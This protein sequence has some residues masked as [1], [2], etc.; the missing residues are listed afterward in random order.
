MKNKI[1][2]LAAALLLMAVASCREKSEVLDNYAFKDKLV[3]QKADTSFAAKFDILWSALD[4]NYNLWD[5]EASQGVDWDKVYDTYYPRF[6]ALDGQYT[7]P[8]TVVKALMNEAFG[9][10]HDGH[11]ALQMKNHKTGKF[12]TC[13]PSDLRNADRPDLEI[14][15]NFQPDLSYYET[16]NAGENKV[17]ESDNV[18]TSFNDHLDDVKNAIILKSLDYDEKS[19]DGG[20][21]PVDKDRLDSLKMFK[22]TLD[23]LEEIAPT[24]GTKGTIQA[25]NILMLHYSYLNVKGAEVY[26]VDMA[27]MG[28]SIKYALLGGN[29]PYI[30]IDGFNLTSYLNAIEQEKLDYLLEPSPELKKK[31]D[32]VKQIWQKWFDKIQ[33][34]SAAGTMK[35][36]VIDVRSNGGGN[37]DD[38]QYLLGAL[39]PSGGHNLMD[40]RQKSGPG[41]YDYTPIISQTMK[42]YEGNHVVVKEPIAVLANCKSVSMAEITC[43]GCQLLDNG[44]V[45]GTRTWGGMC[46]LIDGPEEY[47]Q[48]YSSGLGVQNETAV[49]A[50][51]PILCAFP[52]GKVLDGIGITPD[53]EVTLDSDAWK[54]GYGPDSQL[55]RAL[56]YIRTGN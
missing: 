37:A 25:F 14:A 18:N 56:Q 31:A 47:T 53:I 17:T 42:T 35:G 4:Q 10:L 48:T 50:Y 34:L 9:V 51:I 29:V 52:H 11:L 30:Y 45:V 38:Y 6:K 49:W 8:D 24:L 26:P 40:I 2:I 46:G 13:S 39:L 21:T 15:D 55:D 5:Y 27:S 43:L 16:T 36:V 22:K 1:T 41:R 44:K 28:I 23:N 19:L 3:F 33:E 32:K 20:L 54:E 7:V 12:I